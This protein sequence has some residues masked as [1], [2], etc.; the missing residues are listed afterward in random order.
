V[1][2]NEVPQRCHKLQSTGTQHTP[3]K[4]TKLN[5][6]IAGYIP[7]VRKYWQSTGQIKLASICQIW[8]WLKMEMKTG[9][10]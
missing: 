7:A 4:K 1:H 10:T 3:E 9:R 2:I 5:T 6:K 8:C